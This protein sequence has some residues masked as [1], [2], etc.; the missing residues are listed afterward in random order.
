MDVG[1]AEGYAC[2][3]AEIARLKHLVAAYQ[4]GRFIQ[5]V[6]TL[7]NLWHKVRR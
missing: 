4:Q 6:R 1:C 7:H 3:Y 5:A 2:F